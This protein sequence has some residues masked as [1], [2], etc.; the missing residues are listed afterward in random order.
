MIADMNFGGGWWR[1]IYELV[2]SILHLLQ[3]HINV[4]LT[5]NTAALVAKL[6]ALAANGIYAG[7]GFLGGADALQMTDA[8]GDGTWEAVAT[9]TAG[10]GPNY[11]AFFNSPNTAWDWNTKENSLLFAMDEWELT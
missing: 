1:F 7:G 2:N 11:Y 6:V 10:S 9:V 8:D 4:T 5:V 3:Q